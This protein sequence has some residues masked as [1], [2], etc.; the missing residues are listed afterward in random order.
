MEL[1]YLSGGLSWQAD[2]VAELA[3]DDASLDLNGWVTLTNRSGT[4]Y[5]NAK[6]QLMAGEVNRGAPDLRPMP[7]PAAY[8]GP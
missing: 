5:R 4:A 6:L 8:T 2:Y 1:T 7:D 3:A